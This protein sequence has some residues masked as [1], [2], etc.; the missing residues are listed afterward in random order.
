MLEGF[1]GGGKGIGEM[2]WQTVEFWWG[3]NSSSSGSLSTP[4]NAR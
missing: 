3:N 1:G 2:H 4:S